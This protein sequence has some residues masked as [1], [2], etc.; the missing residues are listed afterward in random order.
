[1]KYL[2]E[3]K[4]CARALALV[5]LAALGSSCRQPDGPMPRP[6][7]EQTNK[8]GDLGHDLLNVAAKRSGA[9]D[10]LANDLA[11]LSGEPP[12]RALIDALVTHLSDGLTG[13]SLTDQSATT[14]AN[15]LFVATT[16][17][18][19]SG[20]QIDTLRRDVEGTLTGAGVAPVKAEPVVETIGAIQA[21]I[22]TNHR[23]WWHWR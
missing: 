4:T 15:Q 23:R 1:M 7:A 17:R 11:N 13:V 8:T 20:R 6:T 14:L 9:H 3:T 18:E 19:L 5:T 2:S 21:A 12:P 10:D 16:A 22:G